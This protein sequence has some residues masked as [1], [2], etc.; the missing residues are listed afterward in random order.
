[1]PELTLNDIL[2]EIAFVEGL[3]DKFHCCRDKGDKTTLEELKDQLQS[4]IEQHD[5]I[6]YG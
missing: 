1:M 4:L 5:K 3:I 2:T 6:R